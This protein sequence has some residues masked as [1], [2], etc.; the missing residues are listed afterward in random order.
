MD[1][2]VHAVTQLGESTVNLTPQELQL[3]ESILVRQ[4]QVQ[5]AAAAGVLVSLHDKVVEESKKATEDDSSQ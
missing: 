1:R 3:L 5:G 4:A 2:L